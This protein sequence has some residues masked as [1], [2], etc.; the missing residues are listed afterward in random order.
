MRLEGFFRV[1][2]YV[3]LNVSELRDKSFWGRGQ[4]FRFVCWRLYV[5]FATA[6]R[7]ACERASRHGQGKISVPIRWKFLYKGCGP[8]QIWI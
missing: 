4:E 5:F 7:A 8:I 1:K 6:V 2:G 3:F